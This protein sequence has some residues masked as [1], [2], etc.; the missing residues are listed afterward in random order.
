[1][2]RR[3]IV[4]KCERCTIEFS[5]RKRNPP[6]RFCSYRCAARPAGC[7]TQA[8]VFWAKVDKDGPIQ[9][10]VPRLG[11]CWVWTAARSDQGYGQLGV[12]GKTVFAH[13]FSWELAHGPIPEDLCVLHHCDNRLCVNR[14]HLFLGTKAANTA[15]MYT[16]GR[17]PRKLPAGVAEEARRRH[18]EGERDASIAA[19]LGIHPTTVWR[20]CRRASA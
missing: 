4:S 5:H 10:H 12:D 2:S 9:P 15:D 11:Q 16:K 6:V 8:D 3:L 13:R 14:D 17:H 7:V 1:V 20:L 18:C 19:D